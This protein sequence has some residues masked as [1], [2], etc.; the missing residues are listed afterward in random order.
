MLGSSECC[1]LSRMH[2]MAAVLAAD[3]GRWKRMQEGLPNGDAEERVGKAELYSQRKEGWVKGLI[4][5]CCQRAVT[6]VPM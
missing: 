2:A 5:Q 1:L 4:P 3:T 6:R